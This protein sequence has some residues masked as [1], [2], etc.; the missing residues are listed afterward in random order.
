MPAIRRMY[1]EFSPYSAVQ[2]ALI[3]KLYYTPSVHG[4]ERR[5]T[6]A[7][8]GSS[9]ELD[10]VDL[11]AKMTSRPTNSRAKQPQA[12]PTSWLSSRRAMCPCWRLMATKP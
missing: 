1:F 6:L 9:Y 5:I 4:L 11:K 7:E 10:R 12:G 2:G 8:A 3:M